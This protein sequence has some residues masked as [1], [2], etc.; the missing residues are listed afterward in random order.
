MCHIL[1]YSECIACKESNASLVKVRE[2]HAQRGFDAKNGVEGPPETSSCED[3]G[4]LL[5]TCR[6]SCC[7]P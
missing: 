4:F 2:S 5:G 7:P 3:G 1:M 6:H